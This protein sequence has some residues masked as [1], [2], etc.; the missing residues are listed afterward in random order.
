M[1]P[2]PPPQV[3]DKGKRTKI[4]DWQVPIQVG[5]QPGSVNGQLFCVPEE[6]SK[7][8]VGAIV[9]LVGVVLLGL[10]AVVLVRR[11]RGSV[12]PAAPS[13]GEGASGSDGGSDSEID[14]QL[15]EAW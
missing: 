4:F 9:A 11:R 7:T 8:P 14:R 15:G 10:A 1:S 13:R 3:K 5:T 12:P 2:V 6:G